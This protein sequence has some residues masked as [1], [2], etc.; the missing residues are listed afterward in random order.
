MVCT[1]GQQEY[2]WHVRANGWIGG[3]NLIY[4]DSAPST[5]AAYCA[6]HLKGTGSYFETSTADAITWGGSLGLV[7]PDVSFQATAETGYDSNASLE[8]D[9]SAATQRNYVC[10]TNTYAFQ[11]WRTVVQSHT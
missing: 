11:A 2:H 7:M 5:N 6:R 10:G 3:Q 9:F 8:Y 4:E 1:G